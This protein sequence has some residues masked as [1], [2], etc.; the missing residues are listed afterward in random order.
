MPGLSVLAHEMGFL[1]EESPLKVI[2]KE[3][4]KFVQF[5]L[6]ALEERLQD[7]VILTWAKVVE[8]F[9]QNIYMEADEGRSFERTEQFTAQ[10]SSK[11]SVGRS[12]R[13]E[14]DEEVVKKVRHKFLPSLFQRVIECY[15]KFG[16]GNMA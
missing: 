9:N 13:G 4:Q 7:G 6:E 5:S 2:D 16:V 3:L 1:K 14:K 12:G 15:F 10:V 8:T 11:F